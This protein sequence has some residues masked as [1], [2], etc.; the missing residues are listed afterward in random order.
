MFIK[1]L[2][3]IW[4]FTTL[5]VVVVALPY[6]IWLGVLA[7]RKQWRKFAYHAL[8][9]LTAYVLLTAVIGLASYYHHTTTHYRVFDTKFD[10]GKPLFEY[11]SERAFNGDGYSIAVYKLPDVVRKRF[12]QPDDRLLSAFPERSSDRSHWSVESW[13]QSPV[14]SRFAKHV[15]FALSAY[16]QQENSKLMDVFNA[17]QTALA[18]ATA[19]YSFFS[20]SPGG[21][22]GNIDFF[23]VDLANGKIYIINHNT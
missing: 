12:E 16:D 8:V 20:Y 14:D 9:P 7:W 1:T 10:L 15:S 17:I 11:D 6:A 3:T 2:E 4:V 5:A 18:G 13:R 19:Y 21:Y 22:V 23:L